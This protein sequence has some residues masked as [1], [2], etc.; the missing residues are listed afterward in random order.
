MLSKKYWIA[1]VCK[2]ILAFTGF[3][4]TIFINRG[5]SIENKGEYSYIINLVEMFCVIFSMSLGQIYATFKRSVGTEVQGNFVFLSLVHSILIVIIGIIIVSIKQFEHGIV[6]VIL[7]ALAVEKVIISMIAVIEESIKR[8]IIYSIMNV[9]YLLLLGIFYFAGKLSLNIVFLFYALNDLISII[10]YMI[11]YKMKLRYKNFR[12][13][14]LKS[15]Y[16]VGFITMVVMLLINVNYYIDTIMLKKMSSFY[17][18]GLYSV[19]VNFSNISLL[20]PDAFKEVLFGDSTKQDFSKN[21]V[22]SSIKVSLLLLIVF[23]VGFIIFGKFALRLFYGADYVLSYQLTFILFIGNFSMIFFKILQPVYISY[24]NQTRA[25]IFLTCSAIVNIIINLLL[26]P[27]YNAVG[28]AIASAVSYTVC[29][30]LFL[31]NYLKNFEKMF[32]KSDRSVKQE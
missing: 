6:I 29:G 13:E 1:I 14:N 22:L 28:A 32:S 3:I 19:G 16:S 8:N 21:V 11:I 30:C 31:F 24:A 4:I 7:A 15:I 17:Y 27:K 25:A 18:L 23:I 20:V 5:L 12:W 2:F 26:I 9:F 10:V